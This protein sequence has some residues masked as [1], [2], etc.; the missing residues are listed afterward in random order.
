MSAR[1]PSTSASKPSAPRAANQQTDSR[2]RWRRSATQQSAEESWFAGEA[3]PD[4]QW[5]RDD[6]AASSRAEGATAADGAPPDSRFLQRHP[7]REGRAGPSAFE[8]SLSAAA[9]FPEAE[10]IVILCGSEEAKKELEK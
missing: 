2:A 9:S 5:R 6:F 7:P 8:R 1:P 3:P 4:T 10:K